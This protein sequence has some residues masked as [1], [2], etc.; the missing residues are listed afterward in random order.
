MRCFCSKKS[1]FFRVFSTLDLHQ[2]QRYR[3]SLVEKNQ[4]IGFFRLVILVFIQFIL[5]KSYGQ[6]QN[7]MKFTFQ[8]KEQIYQDEGYVDSLSVNVEDKNVFIQCK[9]YASGIVKKT[10]YVYL[11]YKSTEHEE[12]RL[13]CMRDTNTSKV[14][15]ELD[16][17][18]KEI[19]FKSKSDKVLMKLPFETLSLNFDQ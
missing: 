2:L 15:V 11:Q 9:D 5:V 18:E 7:E 6:A 12:W 8:S 19:L 10:I 17:D 16:Q 14:K 13:I 3:Y 1:L 4:K